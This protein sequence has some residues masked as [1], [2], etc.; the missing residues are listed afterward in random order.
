[1]IKFEGCLINKEYV[2]YAMVRAYDFGYVLEIRFM[3]DNKYETYLKFNYSTKKEADDAM[4]KLYK[5]LN[6]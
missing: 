3:N 2:G 1:M 4:E 6:K 5:L